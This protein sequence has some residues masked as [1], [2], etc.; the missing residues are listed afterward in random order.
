MITS[1]R[2]PLY[3]AGGAGLSALAVLLGLTAGHSAPKPPAVS[4]SPASTVVTT[5]SNA[6]LGQILVDTQGRTLYGCVKPGWPHRDGVIRRRLCVRG[7]LA[8]PAR[9]AVRVDRDRAR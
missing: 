1:Q 6:G 5:R 9:C 7:R 8:R 2:L 4:T 3:V